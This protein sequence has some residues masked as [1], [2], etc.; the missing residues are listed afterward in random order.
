MASFLNGKLQMHSFQK[1]FLSLK[2]SAQTDSC[3]PGINFVL[4]K[5]IAMRGGDN[6]E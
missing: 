1:A 3:A 4:N 5:L 2:T 6:Y